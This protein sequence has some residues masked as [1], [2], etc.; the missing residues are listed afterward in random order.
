MSNQKIFCNVPWTN[1]HIYWDGSFGMCCNEKEK[2]YPTEHTFDLKNLTISQWFNSG[3]MRQTR[4]Q[5]LSDTKLSQC[6]A[7]YREETFNYESKRIR[8]NFKSVIFTEQAFDRSYQ[9]SP[10]FETFEASREHGITDRLPIDWHIDLGNECNLACKMCEPR[11]SSVISQKY[12]KWGL[13]PQSSNANW[14][15]DEISWENF[16]R[17]ILEVPNINR[18]HFMGGEPLLNKRFPELLQFLLDNNLRSIS[19]SFVTNGTI[20]NDTVIQLLTQ[21]RSCDIEVSIESISENNDYIRQGTNTSIVLNNILYLKSLQTETFR[22][23]LR[24]APQL[25][26]VNNYDKYIRWAWKHKIP[27]QGIPVMHPDYLQISVLPKQIRQQLKS[28]F[29]NLASEL[30][31]S[32]QSLTMLSV[33]RN[34]SNIEQLLIR[35]CNSI[36]EMLDSDEP[37]NVNSLRKE[38]CEWMIRWDKEY[39]FDARQIFPEYLEFFN[40]IQ[41]K[42]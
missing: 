39:S 41:Y 2:P 32:K 31:A 42:I 36:I 30:A 29:V 35:E 5:I 18:L 8:E 9:Q 16:K 17:S 34:S 13:I 23:V 27:I 12:V 37:A 1:T 26:S 6:R 28:N 38:L 15:Q 24:P 20:I 33:G 25:F 14:T 3:P 22:I 11:A 7:C 4:T 40:D 19:V 10:M 21:F